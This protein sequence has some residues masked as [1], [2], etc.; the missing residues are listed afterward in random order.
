MKGKKARK[1]AIGSIAIRLLIID[2]HRKARGSDQYYNI[3][4]MEN[5]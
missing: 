2:F 3:T 4:F 5:N 1:N